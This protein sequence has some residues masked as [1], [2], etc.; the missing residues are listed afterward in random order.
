MSAS[1]VAIQREVP[2]AITLYFANEESRDLFLN[3]FFP[4]RTSGP[5]EESIPG[6]FMV[7]HQDWESIGVSRN[8]V[9]L[10]PREG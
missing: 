6:Y 7:D 8:R 3:A 10:Y 9:H 4:E 1:E 5:P 2:Q